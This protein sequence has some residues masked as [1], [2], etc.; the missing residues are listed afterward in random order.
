MQRQRESPD[1][2]NY[3]ALIS[4]WEKGKQPGRALRVVQAMRRHGVMLNV[5]T[6]SALTSICK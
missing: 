6:Y 4:A 2:T 1:V 5:V 3:N